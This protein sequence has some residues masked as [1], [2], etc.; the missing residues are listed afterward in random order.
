MFEKLVMVASVE[1]TKDEP[2]PNEPTPDEQIPEVPT[3][4]APTPE[5]PTPEVPEE[6]VHKVV[7]EIP[8]PET[9]AQR[10]WELKKEE[11]LS[12]FGIT[13][14]QLTDDIYTVMTATIG[15]RPL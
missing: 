15:E 5:V 4:E 14:N 8:E 12:Q 9:D 13:A 6:V 1:F 2:M 7:E 11:F 3:T 10:E